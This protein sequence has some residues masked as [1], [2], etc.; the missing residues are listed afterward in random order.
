MKKAFTMLEL[1]F[2]IVIVG[3]LSFMAA[4]SFQRNT[5]RE[6]ADQ[7]V[8]HIR[9]TQHLAMMD[10]RFMDSELVNPVNWFKTRWQIFFSNGDDTNNQWSYT[11]FSD[12]L[13]NHTGN[14]DPIEVAINP[15]APEK[16]LTGGANGTNIIHTGDAEATSEMNIGIEY[17]VINVGLNTNCRIGASQKISF[18]Y[19]GRPLRGAPNGYTSPYPA[20]N[21]LISNRCEITLTNAI[22]DNIIIAIEPETGYTHILPN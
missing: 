21:R 2:V 20:A 19:L 8:S 13:G 15:L 4:S 16:R 1:V 17:G 9:Y 10:D 5:L 7:L 3:I 12:K 11:I 22:G 18:D 14:P 6:A